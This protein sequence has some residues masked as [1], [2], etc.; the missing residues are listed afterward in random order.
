MSGGNPISMQHPPPEWFQQLLSAG[1]QAQPGG[2]YQNVEPAYSNRAAWRALRL[3]WKH[4]T[5]DQRAQYRMFVQG[6]DHEG[7]SFIV[8]G[9]ATHDHYR[10]FESGSVLRLRDGH[11]FCLVLT[12]EPVPVADML[13]AKKLLLEN[14]ERLFLA[15]ANDLNDPGAMLQ[16]A[17]E[18][19]R[20]VRGWVS[21]PAPA[22]VP[23]TMGR[24]G[25]ALFNR[26]RQW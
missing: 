19:M 9:N 3:L 14:D 22:P 21:P 10:I 23:N 25:R 18:M 4:L 15:T 20:Q 16:R 1:R 13:L 26:L 5:P 11:R 6:L 24:R 7:H 17:T 8:T 2:D 12:G